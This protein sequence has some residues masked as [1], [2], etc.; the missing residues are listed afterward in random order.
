MLAES[1]KFVPLKQIGKLKSLPF[2]PPLFS[3][4]YKRAKLLVQQ[5]VLQNRNEKCILTT[6]DLTSF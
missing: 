3:L 1:E 4:V 2:F 5:L 6:L